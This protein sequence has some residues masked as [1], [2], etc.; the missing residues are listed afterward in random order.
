MY[1]RV[2]YKPTFKTIEDQEVPAGRDLKLKVSATDQDSEDLPNLK[3]SLVES[4]E[5]MTISEDTG[6][7]RWAPD[8]DQIMLHTVTVMVT[9]GIENS[10]AT[11]EIEVTEG[12]SSSSSLFIIIA[13]VV[14]VA[15]LL[16]LGIL[17]F[18]KQKKK[19]D[20]EALRRGE[21]ERAALEKEREDEYASYEELYGIPAPEK[22]EEG[23][24]TKELKEYIHEKIEELEE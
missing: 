7:I 13:I 5:G 23:L 8:D 24:T 15:I 16:V 4:P 20:E 22:D 3:Y 21:E 12:E 14:I 9:D 17:L 1:F 6:M 11:F 2:N 18:I 10:T 19:V